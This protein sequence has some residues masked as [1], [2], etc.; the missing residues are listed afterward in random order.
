[1]QSDTTVHAAIRS[2]WIPRAVVQPGNRI[3]S[4][5]TKRA[6]RRTPAPLLAFRG[7]RVLDERHGFQKPWLTLLPRYTRVSRLPHQSQICLSPSAP[8]PGPCPSLSHPAR[9][10]FPCSPDFVT[11]VDVAGTR[12][13]VKSFEFVA[14]TTHSVYREKSS[15][16]PTLIT[17]SPAGRS[18]EPPPACFFHACACRGNFYRVLS[19][20]GIRTSVEVGTKA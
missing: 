20:S 4:L 19:G 11:T 13:P 5:R 1:M 8:L 2:G 12:D 3:K 9:L 16:E 15:E 14:K 17:D 18:I 7:I 6:S 10:C